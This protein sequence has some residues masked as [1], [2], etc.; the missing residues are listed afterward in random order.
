MDDL[1]KISRALAKVEE[2]KIKAYSEGDRVLL[3]IQDA[4]GELRKL[5]A[6]LEKLQVSEIQALV[7]FK[8][9]PPKP[10]VRE[11]ARLPGGNAG[12]V[13]GGRTGT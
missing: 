4:P 3:L 2:G 13:K 9:T 12:Q 10:A 8:Q 1:Q 6:A 5:A 11:S 7:T